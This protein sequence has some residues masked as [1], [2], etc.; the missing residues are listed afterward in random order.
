LLDPPVNCS[1]T[2]LR[3]DGLAAYNLPTGTDR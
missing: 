1:L 3:L 2:I